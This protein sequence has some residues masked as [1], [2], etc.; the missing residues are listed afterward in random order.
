MEVIASG[1]Q[2][3]R[4]LGLGSLIMYLYNEGDTWGFYTAILLLFL[5][6][7]SSYLLVFNPA[8][9]TVTRRL[10]LPASGIIFP[11]IAR[12][13]SATWGLLL[14]LGMRLEARRVATRRWMHRGPAAAGVAVA[15]P[16][17]LLL[18]HGS[19][20]NP[21]FISSFLSNFLIS[22]ARVSAITLLSL[23]ASVA[24]AYLALTRQWGVGIAFIGEVLGS[25]PAIIWWPLLSPLASPLPWLVSLVVFLQGSFWY[26]FFNI[27][28]FG[29]PEVREELMELARVYGVK[30]FN[31]FRYI[32]LPS[33]LPSIASGALSAWG[34]AWNSTIV[35]EYFSSGILTVDL[36][37][38]GST[39]A[40]YVYSGNLEAASLTILLWAVMIVVLDKILWSRIFKLVEKTHA[41][42]E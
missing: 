31:Y 21:L 26:E 16:T 33:L 35:A 1:P 5:M 27:M 2:E 34:G 10:M 12:L 25:I 32:L 11:Y 19:L 22:L 24:L 20:A 7:V 14:S 4:L 38:V 6:I 39:L 28:L 15:L 37:G 29:V 17:V 42:G 23:V 30:G 41:V 13:A 36:G 40:R 8:V 18:S 9:N 3:Y